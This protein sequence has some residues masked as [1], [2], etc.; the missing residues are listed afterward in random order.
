MMLS[1][2]FADVNCDENAGKFM[3]SCK[4]VDGSTVIYILI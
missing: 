2:L 3:Q 1:V 4:I